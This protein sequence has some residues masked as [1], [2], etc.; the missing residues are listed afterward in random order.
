VVYN[1]LDDDNR[2]LRLGIYVVFIEA[3]NDQNG[4]VETIKTA[5]VVAAKL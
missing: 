5:M 3:L 2:K 1:G 4:V